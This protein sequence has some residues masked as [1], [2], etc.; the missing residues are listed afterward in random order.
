MF[1]E[2]LILTPREVIFQDK[3]RNVIL[4][5]EKGV[6]EILPYH[7]SI[8]SRLIK[9]KVIAGGKEFPIKRGI[10]KVEANK[11]TIIVER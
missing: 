8:V 7:K 1:L 5:G 2:A 9:G 6:F 3:V 4:P 11:A 10:V